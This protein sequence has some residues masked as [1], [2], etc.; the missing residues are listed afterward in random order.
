MGGS[1]DPVHTAHVALATVALSHLGLDQVRWVPAGQPWQ[2]TRALAPAKH[3]LAMVQLAIAHEPRFVLDP[4]EVRRPGP[5]YTLDTV[6]ALQEAG[7]A[8][9][10]QGAPARWAAPM[11][12]QW[13]LILGQD[14][15]HNLPTWHGWA[16]LVSRV[17]LAV[18][19]R[20][21][22]AL[23]VPQTLREVPHQIVILPMPPMALSST[24]LRG[25][26]AD[27]VSAPSLSPGLI[28]SGVADYIAQHQLYAAGVTR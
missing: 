22:Q 5:S 19:H 24:D 12:P 20:G 13:F 17:T 18:A 6:R 27:G 11:P 14:Q 8:Q 28:P 7:E 10:A 15:L 4:I 25:R 1:F 16:E 26:L 9:E 3:R 23:Q 2:K 21:V